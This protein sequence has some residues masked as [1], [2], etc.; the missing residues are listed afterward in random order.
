MKSCSV[1]AMSKVFVLTNHDRLMYATASQPL[2]VPQGNCIADIHHRKMHQRAV[3][4]LQ[5]FL[6]FH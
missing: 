4:N 5:R 2:T 1:I 6:T 3:N